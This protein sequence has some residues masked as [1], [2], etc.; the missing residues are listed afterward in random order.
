MQWASGNC[1][2]RA[3]PAN[4]FALQLTRQLLPTDCWAFVC[5]QIANNR[6]LT[7]DCQELFDAAVK[8]TSCIH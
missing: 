2:P 1:Q 4:Y 3:G 7:T 6:L 5:Q 8:A